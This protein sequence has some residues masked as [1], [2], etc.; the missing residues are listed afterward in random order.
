MTKPVQ[1]TFFTEL[2]KEPLTVLF[3]TPG[4]IDQ[5]V[6]LGASVSMGILDFSEERAGI[7][8][9]LN[10]K[11]IPLIAW[12]LLPKEQ[13][14]WYHLNNA[15]YATDR[16][17]RFREWSLS[18][19]LKWEAVGIDIEPDINEFQELL[20]YNFRTLL[21]V[22]KRIWKKKAFED[23]C[24]TYASLVAGMHAD[25]YAVHSY[26]FFFTADERMTG[27]SLLSRLFGVASVATDKHIAMLYSSF[28]RPFGVGLLQVYVQAVDSAAIGI[29]GG[30][31]E[32]EGLENKTPMS[33]QEFARDLRIAG[34]CRGD[35]AIFS[36]EGCVEQ[37]FL[38]R[39]KDFD[40][41]AATQCPRR[42][43]LMVSLVRYLF[44]G[45]LW[46]LANPLFV[47]AAAIALVWAWVH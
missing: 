25:G 15:D 2:E 23:S 36:L 11:G 5:L 47:I 32:L 46:L 8:R 43:V 30:G 28:F 18:H 38:Y 31:V 40:W 13:G 3:S 34:G 24:A 26:E 44:V 37:G 21:S 14:Y 29:T 4:V 12:Q 9:Q 20:R 10:A 22:V 1:L 45:L 35:V 19:D 16:Y 7:V 33:W 42:W 39:L 27:S 6:S 17:R 41:D